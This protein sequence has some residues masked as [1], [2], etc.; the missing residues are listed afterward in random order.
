M[1]GTMTKPSLLDIRDWVENA[2]VKTL[3]TRQGVVSAFPSTCD[4]EIVAI[5]A[6]WLY[7]G[8]ASEEYTLESI[9]DG[10]KPTPINY[11]LTHSNGLPYDDGCFCGVLSNA[12]H[13]NLINKIHDGIL[14]HK[15]GLHGCF[16]NYMQ[17]KRHKCK[18]A[19]D[20]FALM[21][22]GNTGF[23]TRLSRGTFFRFNY[24][25]YILYKL[26]IWSDDI[27]MSKALLPCNDHVMQRALECGV[28]DKP[29]RSDLHGTILITKK[30]REMF[31]EKDFY[32]LWE[33]LNFAKTCIDDAGL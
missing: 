3:D 19:H 31:G 10:M 5:M 15:D 32:I 29:M 18:Y 20:A 9:V 22:S 1:C 24:L 2:D 21:L 6:S 12:H 26:N 27:A 25:Y 23:P 17:G 7:N 14:Y 16:I 8:H 11:V 13:A 28:I 33:F 4:K 30:A